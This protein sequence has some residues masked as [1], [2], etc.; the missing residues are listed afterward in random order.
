MHSR[1]TVRRGER[2]TK[3]GSIAGR[4]RSRGHLDY[5][6]DRSLTSTFTPKTPNPQAPQNTSL[7]NNALVPQNIPLPN[8]LKEKNM[9]KLIRRTVGIKKRGTALIV[10]LQ[11]T[12]LHC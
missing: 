7:P 4:T 11:L 2:P 9:S 6:A 8:N 10:A 12:A 1:F 5:H 3:T